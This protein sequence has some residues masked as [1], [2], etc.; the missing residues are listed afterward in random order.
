MRWN[1]MEN[2]QEY[3]VIYADPPWRYNDKS[4][5]RGGAERHYPTMNIKDICNLKIPAKENSILF[6]WA[7]F[8]LLQDALNVIQSWGFKYKTCAFTWVK[9]NKKTNSIYMGM[10]HY[11]RS[12]AEI[13]LL[14]TKG[15][16]LPKVCSKSVKNT[17][18]FPVGKHSAK[19]SEFRNLIVQLYGE[20]T[21]KL[22]M[23]AREKADGW[24]SW[25]NQI[26][27]AN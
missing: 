22:E 11:T 4:L 10:G 23:F 19:P 8:P 7:T 5:H 12:N 20:T 16:F 3:D 9:T 21:S 24:D 15:K 6:M 2:L 14:A 27:I 18:L 13:C 25:G 17:H 26:E 1:N